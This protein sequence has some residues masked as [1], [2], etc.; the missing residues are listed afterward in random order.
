MNVAIIIKI[1]IGTFNVAI[2]IRRY[3]FL[4]EYGV[5]GNPEMHWKPVFATN[6][7]RYPVVPRGAYG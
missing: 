4:C 1:I 5:I 2:Y 3:S 6:I 7:Q